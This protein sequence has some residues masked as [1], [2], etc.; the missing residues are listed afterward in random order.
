[1]C[2]LIERR[3]LVNF[4]VDPD[5]LASQLPA[6]FRPK[7][8]NGAGMAGICLIRLGQVRPRGMPR[9]L[10]IASENA[11]HRFAVEWQVDGLLREGVY[12][13]RRDTNSRLNALAGGRLFPGVHHHARFTVQEDEES[14]AIEI[15][16]DDRTNSI[17]VQGRRAEQLPSTTIFTSL[18]EASRFFQGGALGYSATPQ[19]GRFH[20]LEL[21]CLRWHVEPLHVDAVRSSY[22]DDPS[23]FP[24][25]SIEFD[26]ALL[27]RDIEH[28]W[29]ARAELCCAAR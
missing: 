17:Y 15:A 9:W 20:G 6:P 12:V 18:P 19:P 10:G 3:I 23:R 27:M 22:F 5:V 16:S 8:V 7:L 29:H 26:C 21:N 14:Y 2:G 4:H 11:A 25:G 13:C 24:A 1:M 28:Q